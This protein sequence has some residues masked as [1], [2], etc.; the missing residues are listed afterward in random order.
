VKL[1][2]KI[3]VAGEWGVGTDTRSDK[4]IAVDVGRIAFGEIGKGEGYQLMVKR[5]PVSHQPLW[6]KHEIVPRAIDRE[7]AEAFRRSTLGVDQGYKTLIKHA[8]RISLADKWNRPI[9]A[10]D[11][12]RTTQKLL[13]RMS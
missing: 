8:S 7:V 5:A 11:L 6:Q 10:T 2:L 3:A 4:E 1:G 13:R 12:K 9:L